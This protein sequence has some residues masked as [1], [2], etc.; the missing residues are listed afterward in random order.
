MANAGLASVKVRARVAVAV[1]NSC[2]MDWR[3]VAERAVVDVVGVVGVGA[4][5]DAV[6]R[7]AISAREVFIF[8]IVRCL[9]DDM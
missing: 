4:N 3:R 8:L 6:A 1:V 5:A 2:S 7:D 9:L